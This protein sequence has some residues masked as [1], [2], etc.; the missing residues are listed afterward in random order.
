FGI[1]LLQN[2]LPLFYITILS[3]GTCGA[4]AIAGAFCPDIA[5]ISVAVGGLYGI[6]FGATI[7]SFSMYTLTYFDQYRATATAV[8]YASRSAAGVVGPSLM[9]VISGY[10][11]LHGFFR[12]TLGTYDNLYVMLGAINL[13]SAAMLS[14]LVCRDC[15]R[16]KYKW[17]PR[18]SNQP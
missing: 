10:Y 9:S 14:I 4:G 5:W 15:A 12:D 13:L 2:K 11:G 3:I 18:N 1:M 16:R 8:K 17:T 6:G 7:T